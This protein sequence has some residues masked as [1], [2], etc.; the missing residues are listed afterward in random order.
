MNRIHHVLALSVAG[1]TAE[2]VLTRGCKGK[3]L[4]AVSFAGTATPAG[5]DCVLN[6]GPGRYT[7]RVW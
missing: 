6:R 7:F 3:H 1:M 5:V 2:V 4:A